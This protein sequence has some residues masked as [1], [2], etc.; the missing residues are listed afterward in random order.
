MIG[1]TFPVAHSYDWKL[2]KKKSQVRELL[3]RVIK[4]HCPERHFQYQFLVP[5]ENHTA[6]FLQRSFP[7]VCKFSLKPAI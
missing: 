6:H 1:Y 2:D 4:I 5:I 3:L 7:E